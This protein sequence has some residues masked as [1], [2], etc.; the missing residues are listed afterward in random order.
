MVTI[1]LK[2]IEVHRIINR[3]DQGST[4][5]HY[6]SVV[7]SQLVCEIHYKTS[8]NKISNILIQI[9]FDKKIEE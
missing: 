1:I 2:M 8:N 3:L 4:S 6:I 5:H 7:S 9:I